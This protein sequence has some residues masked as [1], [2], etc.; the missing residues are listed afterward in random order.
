MTEVTK[1]P[2]NM[3]EALKIIKERL[4]N[5]KIQHGSDDLDIMLG[6]TLLGGGI[7]ERC[8]NIGFR[9]VKIFVTL[10]RDISNLEENKKTLIGYEVEKDE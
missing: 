4:P 8:L 1:E 7:V 9:V 10:S 5:V 3:E 2:E 6:S